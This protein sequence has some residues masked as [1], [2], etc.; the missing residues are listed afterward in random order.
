MRE[1]KKRKYLLCDACSH[2][3]NFIGGLAPILKERLA[4]RHGVE[5]GPED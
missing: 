1:I 3:A 5:F 4:S 2:P